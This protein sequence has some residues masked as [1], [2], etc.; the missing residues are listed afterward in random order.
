ML[1]EKTLDVATI[2]NLVIAGWTG[3]NLEALEAH[4]KSLRRL[5]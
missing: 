3:R 2:Q 1:D 4:I 5:V